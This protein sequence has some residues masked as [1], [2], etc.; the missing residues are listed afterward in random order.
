MN[1]LIDFIPLVKESY[2][3]AIRPVC[4]KYNMT[5]AEFD[6]LLFLANN[7]EFDRA[8]DIVEKRYIVKSQV[9]TS[10]NLLEK[11]GYLSRTYKENDRKT[12]HL[13]LNDLARNAIE[14]GQKAQELFFDILLTGFS[15]EQKILIKKNMQTLVDNMKAFV[16]E[17]NEL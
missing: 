6:V 17:E 9:S 5:T 16:Q 8:T 13:I 12:I 7:P 4:L 2:T 15:D 11:K 14:D 1:P 10:I 3:K